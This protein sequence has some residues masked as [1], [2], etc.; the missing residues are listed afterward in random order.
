[1][2]NTISI[3]LAF[4]QLIFWWKYPWVESHDMNKEI[5]LSVLQTGSVLRHFNTL[6]SLCWVEWLFRVKTLGS[7]LSWPFI[8]ACTWLSTFS[9]GTSTFEYYNFPNKC[10]LTFLS[11]PQMVISCLNCNFLLP[12][13]VGSLLALQCFQGVYAAF[14]PL[15]SFVSDER[16]TNTLHSPQVVP[17][18]VRADT[19]NYLSI[20]FDFPFCNQ[21]P[22][23][24][25]G[26]ADNLVQGCQ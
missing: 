21:G 3:A 23:S 2:V 25:A 1:M 11:K 17:R 24:P 6:P 4:V 19:R 15:L 18:Q 14:L 12:V 20:K 13:T 5:P 22:G 16:E 9:K 26:N 8:L 7:F 10:S